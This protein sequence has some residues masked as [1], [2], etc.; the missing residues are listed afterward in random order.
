M[1]VTFGSFV[2]YVKLKKNKKVVFRYLLT[3]MRDAG[4]RIGIECATGGVPS[5]RY[6]VVQVP[7][8]QPASLGLCEVEVYSPQGRA[9]HQHTWVSTPL[10]HWGGRKSSA[11]DARIEAP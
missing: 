5:V 1:L 9:V 8:S 3:P 2:C 11:E 10:G 7:A 6:V 4:A